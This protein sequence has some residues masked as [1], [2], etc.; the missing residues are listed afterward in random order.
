MGTTLSALK[1]VTT[2]EKI[3][4]FSDAMIRQLKDGQIDIA[5]TFAQIKV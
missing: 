4:D 1:Y 2:V 3:K 5:E